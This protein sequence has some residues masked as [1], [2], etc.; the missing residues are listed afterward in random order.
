MKTLITSA[1]LVAAL[2]FS[3][4]A[5]ADGYHAPKKQ[6]LSD[7][8]V[9]GMIFTGVAAAIAGPSEFV[10]RNLIIGGIVGAGIGEAAS[11]KCKYTNTVTGEVWKDACPADW[12]Y[13]KKKAMKGH[14]TKHGHYYYKH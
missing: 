6:Q 11:K 14:M 4:A 9:A 3:T 13:E 8:A 5:S 2:T 12:E 7:E 10:V 1:A